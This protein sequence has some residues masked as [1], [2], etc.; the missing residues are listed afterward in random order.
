MIRRH[1]VAA[2][3]LGAGRVIAPAD[4]VLKRTSSEQILTDLAPVYG[5]TL[6]RDI[7]KNAPFAAADI[8]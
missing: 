6:K 8:E 3:A 7:L 1:V 5:K 2:E 4:L